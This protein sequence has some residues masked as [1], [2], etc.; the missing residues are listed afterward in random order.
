ME[1]ETL[2]KIYNQKFYNALHRIEQKIPPIWLMRQAGRYH[3]H[4]QNLKT[5]HTFEE[6]C[7]TP[8]LICETTMGPIQD[9]DFDAAI[10]F[11]DI[12]FPLDYLGMG[13]TFNPGPEFSNPLTEQILN[14][15]KEQSFSD[16]IK[17]QIN[18]LT[19]IRDT[20]PKNKSLIGFVGA[21]YTL[22][23]F[24]QRHPQSNSKLLDNFL[25]IVEKI[26]EENID[27]QFSVDLD[28][29]MIFDTEAQHLSLDE[30]NKNV[31]PFIE[32]IA[33]KYPGKI[34]YFTK[35]IDNEKFESL[36]TIIDLKLTVVGSNQD[37]F[38]KLSNTNLS[39]QGNFFNEYLAIED[40]NEFKKHLANFIK[41]IKNQDLS[42][43]AGWICSLD[44]G[45][46]KTT[47]EQNVKLFIETIR[48]QL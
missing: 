1:Q 16:Y 29:L 45:V 6:L 28:I 40:I 21:P 3:L 23:K 46:L 26:L 31:K 8:E 12:L 14:Q 30:F 19:M 2:S 27:L 9:F 47:P 39:L 5:K 17:F 7:K 33:I 35:D 48:T 34:G 44:P 20:L 11:S 10:L 24:A 42:K 41:Y 32:K 22:F 4:Y 13:L 37:I 15:E 43:R 18:G 38:S 36:K 25:P